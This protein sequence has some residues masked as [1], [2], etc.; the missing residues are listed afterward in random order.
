MK[1]TITIISLILS[2]V[3]I[4]DTMNVWHALF[5]FYLAGEIPG[6]RSSV[7][8]SI[9]LQ[10]FALLIGFVLARLSNHAVLYF[11]RRINF[12]RAQTS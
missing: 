10:V 2:A 3:L 11:S 12:R 1:K 7:S 6:T 5:M 4:L 9:M 8:A